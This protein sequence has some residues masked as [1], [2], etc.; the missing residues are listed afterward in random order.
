[1]RD[2]IT[3]KDIFG[4]SIMN[5]YFLYSIYI[6]EPPKFEDTIYAKIFN[7][8]AKERTPILGVPKR[9]FV[10]DAV[11]NPSAMFKICIHKNLIKYLKEQE[12]NGVKVQV[13]YDPKTHIWKEK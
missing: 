2:V 7:Q 10:M 13:E 8:T 1:M 4:S 12:A 3:Y 9:W 5:E 11:G 6:K